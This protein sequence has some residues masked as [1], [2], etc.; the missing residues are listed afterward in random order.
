MYIRYFARADESELGRTAAAYCNVLVATG[1]PVRLVSTRLDF[2]AKGRASSVWDETGSSWERHRELLL[3]P[4]V[5][6]FVNVVCSDVL[7]WAKL[8]TN[9]CKNVLIIAD[10][11]MAPSNAQADIMTGMERY[12]VVYTVSDE[13]ADVVER[14]TGNRPVVMYPKDAKAALR[15]RAAFEAS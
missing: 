7:D 5:G 12:D 4:M 11:N 2:D 1:L 14:V 8:W 15:M 13:L 3:T 6:F 9:G 10:A